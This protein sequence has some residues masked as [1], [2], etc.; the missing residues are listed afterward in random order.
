[1]LEGVKSDLERFLLE[2]LGFGDVTSEAVIPEEVEIE[3][4][5]ISKERG[6]IAG[7]NE[8]KMVFEMVGVKV[9]VKVKDG[10]AVE[11][12]QVIMKV[13]GRAR[14]ILGAERTALNI[15]M[16]MSG[17]ATETAKIVETARR[18]NSKVRVACTR[19]TT[20]GFRYFE[21]KAVEA[22][23]G[24]PHRF[25]LDDMILIK[26]NHVKIVGS[27][28]EAIRRAR[29]RASFS[30][31]IEVEVSEPRDA[32]EA[33]LSGADVIMLDNMSKEKVR[34]TLML[35]EQKGVRKDV[36]IEVSGGISLENVE[37]YAELDVDVLSLGYVTHSSKALDLSLYVTK[38]LKT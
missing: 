12:G 13:K 36:I 29:E 37:E 28:S 2:D 34:E 27:V 4:E 21:K 8:A 3:G 22:G 5:I 24:D 32:L 25:R 38:I 16:I 1:M 26:N 31:K 30:K 15:L 19:K 11:K 6:I 10:D 18:L 14:T 20:P 23:G 17:I 7:V 35:L 33:A 9:D